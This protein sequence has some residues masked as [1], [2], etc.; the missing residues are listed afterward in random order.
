VVYL[1]DADRRKVLLTLPE[2]VDDRLES[3]I[4]V[5]RAAQVQV[6]RSQIIAALIAAAPTDP[7]RLA[8]VVQ[9]YL[10]ERAEA[11]SQEHPGTNLPDVHHPGAKR[12]DAHW[13]KR[14]QIQKPLLAA[15]RA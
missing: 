3:L 2:P 7:G 14:G 8:R 1:S 6:S 5:A 13:S 11:F 4:R 10:G 9:R 15:L 12:G